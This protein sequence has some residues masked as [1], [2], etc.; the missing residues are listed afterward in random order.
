MREARLA[1]CR[2]ARLRAL[3]EREIRRR[4]PV[5]DIPSA[6]PAARDA[7]AAVP[8]VALR[9]LAPWT[10]LALALLSL[11]YLAAFAPDGTLHEVLHDGRHLLAFPCH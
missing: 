10:L 11:A 6:A 8:V 9:D 1:G 5:S 4:S 3:V 7:P 2:A